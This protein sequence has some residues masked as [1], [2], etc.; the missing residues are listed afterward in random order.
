MASVDAHARVAFLLG[1]VEITLHAGQHLEAPG[2][3][4]SLGLDFLDANTI[5]RSGFD[6]GFGAFGRG[7]ADTVEVEAG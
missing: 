6:P 5:R 4:R 2:H 1:K 7:R 3:I